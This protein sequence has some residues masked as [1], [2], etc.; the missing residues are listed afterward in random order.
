KVACLSLIVLRAF[1][2]SVMPLISAG[3]LFGPISTKSL[4][5][6]GHRFT[7][8]P[9]ATN[10]CSALL[11]CTNTTSASPRRAVSS[12]WPMPTA[13]T[14]TARPVLGGRGGRKGSNSQDFFV[15]VP[16]PTTI[17][18]SGASTGP[19]KVIGRAGQHPITAVTEAVIAKGR[20]SRGKT[21]FQARHFLDT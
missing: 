9:S 4:Y 19:R 21:P 16:E 11:L 3:S 2:T 14:F 15:E 12:A 5:I 17:V 20:D 8:C 13:T 7:P 6:T 10:C 18:F 1:A